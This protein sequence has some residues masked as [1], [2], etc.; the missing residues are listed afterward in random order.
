MMWQWTHYGTFGSDTCSFQRATP[1]I[2]TVSIIAHYIC[3]TFGNSNSPIGVAAPSLNTQ[4]HSHVFQ[5]TVFHLLNYI[6]FSTHHF[7]ALY[8]GNLLPSSVYGCLL[9]SDD[10]VLVFLPVSPLILGRLNS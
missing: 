8:I 9:Q 6:T 2:F 1:A 4:F 7:L 10:R 3:F 5:V